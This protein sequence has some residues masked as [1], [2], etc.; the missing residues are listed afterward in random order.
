MKKEEAVTPEEAVKRRRKPVAVE[1]TAAL[2]VQEE[3]AP[4]EAV[5]PAAITISIQS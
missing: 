3:L 5:K 2:E 4:V 1:E